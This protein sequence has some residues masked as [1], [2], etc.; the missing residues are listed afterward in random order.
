MESTDAYSFYETLQKQ[1]LALDKALVNQLFET[2]HYLYPKSKTEQEKEVQNASRR[3]EEAQFPGLALQ[4][5]TPVPVVVNSSETM[6]CVAFR[7]CYA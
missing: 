2:I 1:E 7:W 3:R 4:N 6:G 5:T